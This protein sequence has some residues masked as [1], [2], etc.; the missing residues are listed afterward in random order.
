MNLEG[1]RRRELMR[2]AGRQEKESG[3]LPF[4][5]FLFS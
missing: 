4:P 3:S 2:K 1:R 5:V